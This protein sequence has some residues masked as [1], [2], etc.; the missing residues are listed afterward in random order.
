[1]MDVVAA[2]LEAACARVPLGET[3][4]GGCEGGEEVPAFT[5][6]HDGPSLE[7]VW[8]GVGAVV[9]PESARGADVET[10]TFEGELLGAAAVGLVAASVLEDRKQKTRD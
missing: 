5:V 3:P 7:G 2:G 9:L 8:A 4:E 6:S 10:G 1:M